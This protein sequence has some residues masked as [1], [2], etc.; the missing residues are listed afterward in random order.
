VAEK[1]KGT[2]NPALHPRDSKGRFTRSASKVMKPADVKLAKKASDGFNP[3]SAVKASGSPQE[4]MQAHG[5]PLDGHVAEY[6]HGDN[7]KATNAALRA[8]KPAPGSD[9]IDAAM[10]GLPEDALL[11]REIPLS[12]FAH[13]PMKDL[14]GMKVRDAAYASTTLDVPGHD[15]RPDMV[16]MHIAAP[17]GTKAII[18]AEDGEILL[19]RDTEVAISKAEPNGKGGWDLYGVVIPKKNAPGEGDQ[20]T[21]SGGGGD[22]KPADE[23]AKA[24]AG[25]ADTPAEPAADQPAEPAAPQAGE[26]AD[27]EPAA[28][29]ATG[30]PEG[31]GA[32]DTTD[33]PADDQPAGSMF[34]S[35]EKVVTAKDLI[36]LQAMHMDGTLGSGLFLYA[37]GDTQFINHSAPAGTWNL[38]DEDGDVLFEHESLSTVLDR[39]YTDPAEWQLSGLAQDKLAGKGP[40]KAAEPKPEPA[41]EPKPEPEPKAEPK[42]E[43]A[44]VAAALT[45]LGDIPTGKNGTFAPSKIGMKKAT[46][47]DVDYDATP[48]HQQLADNDLPEPADVDLSTAQ[49]VSMQDFVNP[50]VVGKYIEQQPGDDVPTYVLHNGKY[51]ILDGTHRT[52]AELLKGSPTIK[53]H[54]FDLDHADKANKDGSGDEGGPQGKENGAASEPNH[55]AGNQP[56]PEAPAEPAAV[57]KAAKPKPTEA[58]K[59]AALEKKWKDKPVPKAPVK[60][61]PP[62]VDQKAF[63]GGWLAAVTARYDAQK[64]GKKL[65]QSY[66]YQHVQTAIEKPGTGEAKTAIKALRD[67]KYI[68][69]ELEQQYHDIVDHELPK[70]T[71]DPAYVKALKLYQTRTN[72]HKKD[73][74]AW[75]Q[76]NGVGDVLH[77][78]AGDVVVHNSAEDGIAWADK[79]FPAKPKAGSV[80][81]LKKYTGSAYSS[82]N[83]ALRKNADANS[84]PPGYADDTKKADAGMSEFPEDAILNRGT[85]FDEFVF[86]D[87]TRSASVPPPD[88][89]DLIGS[90]QVQHG[91]MSTS[92][93]GKAAFSSSKVQMTVRVPK[94]HKG[95]WL[96][97]ISQHKG[98][99]ELLLQRSTQLFIHDAFQKDGKWIIEA[100]VLPQG[101]PPEAVAGQLPMP[102]SAAAD[103]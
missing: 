5:K 65:E 7:W 20:K 6:L 11:R 50:A 73:V 4:W 58:E 38:E 70:P 72:R 24:D 18:N 68:D 41:P 8:G 98:E 32:P 39:A 35:N 101:M 9:E 102:M 34:A 87:G 28:T 42:A 85:N 1:K 103:A 97:P 37:P 53:A 67:G 93:G 64:T 63:F 27:A 17:A 69:A 95:A 57:K 71:E 86:P 83:A 15:A 14:E 45:A 49:F 60:P 2:W 94:G 23:P 44:S 36:A 54:V 76:V 90:V 52:A 88:P 80:A 25:K 92:V 81:A 26:P 84:L 96:K 62:E 46:A 21:D 79:T 55:T 10:Q 16:T 22:G 51:V 30:E 43:P 59:Q 82:W 56:E 78:M 33:Q 3:T 66:N 99:D 89:A 19:A 77:G 61:K 75:K 74:A 91:Y 13:I 100:E 29:A 40:K 48:I 31:T 47:K 12:L